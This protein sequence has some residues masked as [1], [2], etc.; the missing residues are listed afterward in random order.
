VHLLAA[1]AQQLHQAH[2]MLYEQLLALVVGSGLL[3]LLLLLKLLVCCS[4]RL[5]H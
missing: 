1:D 5:I 2:D 4:L 3:L